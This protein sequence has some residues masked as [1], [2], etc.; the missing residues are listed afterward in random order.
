MF[1]KGIP[2]GINQVVKH[3]AKANNKYTVDLYNPYETSTYFPFWMETTCMVGKW[4]KKC[5]HM[6][7]GVGRRSMILSLKK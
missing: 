7:L 3:H 5:Q 2:G 4:E 1:E 6:G